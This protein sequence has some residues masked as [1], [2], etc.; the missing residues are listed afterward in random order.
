LL[1]RVFIGTPFVRV[2][3]DYTHPVITATKF[4]WS[5]VWWTRVSVRCVDVYDAVDASAVI[6]SG[7]LCIE[8][9][10]TPSLEFGE[11]RITS[12]R[13]RVKILIDNHA[14]ITRQNDSAEIEAGARS[15]SVR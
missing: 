2:D 1:H 6:D 4:L 11:K 12:F 13:K 10:V 5:G 8:V 15:G 14:T 7:A 3:D 9:P